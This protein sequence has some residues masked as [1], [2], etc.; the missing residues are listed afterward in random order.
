MKGVAAE[1]GEPGA[2]ADKACRKFLPDFE[3]IDRPTFKAAADAVLAGGLGMLPIENES[4]GTV[5]GN[6]E[7]ILRKD[8][9]VREGARLPAD[10]GDRPQAA[11]ASEAA[12][13]AN[14]LTILPRNVHDRADN[15]TTLC[16]AARDA[17]EGGD[18]GRNGTD[19]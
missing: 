8:L 2:Y 14:G 6:R 3:R 13:V 19:R 12:A 7:P 10:G 17:C 18:G 16:V 4:A 5:P 15:A 9:S 1:Q 11:V